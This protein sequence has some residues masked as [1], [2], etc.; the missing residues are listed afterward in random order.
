M[1]VSDD[2]LV[3]H[4]RAALSPQRFP[5]RREAEV[6]G[7]AGDGRD[8]ISFYDHYWPAR[9]VL[10]I[11]TAR[12]AGGDVDAA[13]RATGLRQLLRAV[14]ATTLSAGQALEALAARVDTAGL[15]I[16][17][18]VLDVVSG[19]VSYAARGKAAVTISGR[20]NERAMVS[21]DIAWLAAGDIDSP[22][23]AAASSEG[24]AGLIRDGI[25]RSRSGAACALLFKTPGR[26]AQETIFSIG[27]SHGDIQVAAEKVRRFLE[28]H[29]VV[30]EDVTRIDVALDEILTNA[31]NYGFEDGEAHE[32]LLSLSIAA[33]RLAIEVQDDGRPFDPLG[34]PEPDLDADLESRQI[35]GLGMHFVRTLLDRVSYSR[36]NG[37]NVL[38]L[39][40]QLAGRTDRAS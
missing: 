14:V 1:A 37:W 27:N 15:D 40:K 34:I 38:S 26:L 20:T 2:G 3:A 36:R 28:M 30:E 18:L 25:D 8:A 6:E 22:G 32:I 21:G 24:I 17:L 4:L 29:G 23:K 31:V 11:S 19:K 16:G 10:A 9:S 35:G 13:L 5:V 39:E 33:D 12:V 7:G